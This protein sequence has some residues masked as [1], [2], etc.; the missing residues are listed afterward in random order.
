MALVDALDLANVFKLIP[1][2]SDSIVLAWS[3]LCNT[4]WTD[5]WLREHPSITQT[6]SSLFKGIGCTLRT[7]VFGDGEVRKDYLPEHVKACFDHPDHCD[8]FNANR[9]WYSCAMLGDVV[10]R[11]VVKASVR[12]QKREFKNY[13]AQDVFCSKVYRETP[14]TIKRCPGAGLLAF[15]AENRHT[16]MQLYK[17]WKLGQLWGDGDVYPGPDISEKKQHELAER[18]ETIMGTLWLISVAAIASTSQESKDAAA[19][20][21]IV[22]HVMTWISVWDV[23]CNPILAR[24]SNF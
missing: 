12:L 17:G 7:E 14:A 23:Q 18:V 10:L 19:V 24:N 2:A 8:R 13:I 16:A 9:G 11:E 3:E 15:R 6:L 4:T 22:G 1:E 21:A 5:G 20:L